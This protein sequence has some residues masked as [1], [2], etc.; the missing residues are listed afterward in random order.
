LLPLLQG[1][2]EGAEL[3]DTQEPHVDTILV[4][5]AGS[6]F[7]DKSLKGKVELLLIDD[8]RVEVGGREQALFVAFEPLLCRIAYMRFFEA[9]NYLPR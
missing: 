8:T 6:L 2:L 3:H 4:Q 5:V 7:V 1:G 9:A